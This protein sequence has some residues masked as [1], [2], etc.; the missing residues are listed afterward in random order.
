[1]SPE[2]LHNMPTAT[3]TEHTRLRGEVER[4]FYS[5]ANFSAGRLKLSPAPISG[6]PIQIHKFFSVTPREFPTGYCRA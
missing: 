4:V 6:L 3:T 1:M 5:S 2:V